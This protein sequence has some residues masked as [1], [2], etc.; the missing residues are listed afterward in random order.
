[1]CA[2]AS[3]ACS[4]PLSEPLKDASPA[5]LVFKP[6]G[7]RC[8]CLR[9]SV[10][11]RARV[12]KGRWSWGRLQLLRDSISSTGVGR[13]GPITTLKMQQQTGDRVAIVTI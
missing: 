9:V 5:P 6:V 7:V 8:E 10:C 11:V 12:L 2:L 3:K 13:G 4:Q 1:M